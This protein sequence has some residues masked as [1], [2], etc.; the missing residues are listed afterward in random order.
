MSTFYKWRGRVH[1]IVRQ[2][3]ATVPP[4]S[5]FVS[6]S[7]V[8]HL[9]ARQWRA[10]AAGRAAAPP[11]ASEEA[12]QQARDATVR[13]VALDIIYEA[14]AAATAELSAEVAAEV[15]GRAVFTVVRRAR[16]CSCAVYGLI[17]LHRG[18][19]A[20]GSGSSRSMGSRRAK[21]YTA[22]RA[23]ASGVMCAPVSDAFEAATPTLLLCKAAD[24]A[25]KGALYEQ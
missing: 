4:P 23:A 19:K 6:A 20:E 25:A 14:A 13:A 5:S 21:P 11:L 12:L 22:A 2:H 16:L 18:V 10:A 17:R 24:H 15:M 7:P 9:L 3:S 1:K 8:Q